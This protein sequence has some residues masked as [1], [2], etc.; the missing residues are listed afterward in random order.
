MKP[1]LLA[2]LS[3]ISVILGLT[4]LA[5]LGVGLRRMRRASLSRDWPRVPGTIQSSTTVSRPAPALSLEGEDE[6]AAAR[7]PQMLHRPEVTYTYTVNGRAFTGSALG[8]EQ[9]EISD[10]SRARAHAARYTP[11]A[12][13][14]VFHDPAD[15]S[16]ALLEPGV[17]AASGLLPVM[18]VI[19]LVV[20][21]GLA[22]V[23]LWLRAR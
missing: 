8:L 21:G 16:R 10:E 11:G 12:P 6:E 7:P 17:H 2:L 1:L 5:L 14:T 9:V 22:L 19:F 23:V 4:G 20:T 15:P 13:V 18:G 3:T